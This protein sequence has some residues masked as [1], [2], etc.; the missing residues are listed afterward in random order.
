MHLGWLVYFVLWYKKVSAQKLLKVIFVVAVIYSVI[1]LL[2]QVT[3]PAFA[4]FGGRTIG[5]GYAEHF[6]GGVE[7]RMGFYRFCVGGSHYCMMA[8]LLLYGLSK[9]FADKRK[10]CLLVIFL[11]AIVAMGSRT[12]LLCLA[13]S[14]SLLYL[15]KKESKNKFLK[16]FLLALAAYFVSTFASQIF[17]QLANVQDDLEEGRMESYLYYGQEL[18]SDKICMIF[19]NGLPHAGSRY[20]QY[21]DWLNQ[22]YHIIWADV[23][24][25]GTAYNWG[26]LYVV[27]YFF[28]SLRFLFNK[29]LDISYKAIMLLPLFVCWVQS[30]LWEFGGFVYQG[31]LF[32]LCDVNILEN[33]KT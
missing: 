8:S 15:W 9:S 1:T 20:G 31:I 4:P 19:G 21:T 29:Y 16:F 12:T 27:F 10:I 3:Y 6:S 17:G 23:G 18:V 25:L 33:K 5:T 24:F 14:F 13:L 11:L 32:Y 7:K 22:N 30:P 26:L 28:V 2:Q